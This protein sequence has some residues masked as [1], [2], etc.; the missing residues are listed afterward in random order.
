MK[1]ALREGGGKEFDNHGVAVALVAAQVFAEAAQGGEGRLVLGEVDENLMRIVAVMAILADDPAVGKILA[2]AVV[3]FDLAALS[4]RSGIVGHEGEGFIGGHAPCHGVGAEHGLDT[5]G[6]GDGWP[7]R[8]GSHADHASFDGHHRV[9]ESGAVVRGIA[10]NCHA[11]SVLLGLVDRHLHGAFG[12]VVAHAIVAVNDGGRGRFLHYVKIRLG[13]LGAGPNP[14]EIYR[15]ETPDS[16]GINASLIG[17]DKDVGANRGFFGGNA[18]GFETR[19][20]KRFDFVEI[21]PGDTLVHWKL[22][23]Y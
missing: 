8:C 19:A 11:E 3:E 15:L 20:H 14:V 2:E 12:D 17:G 13:Q 7:G 21:P 4:Y 10:D 22:L 23:M 9:V 1:L 6:G 16:M 5:P 18:D